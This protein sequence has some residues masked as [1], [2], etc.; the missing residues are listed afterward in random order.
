MARNGRLVYVFAAW[1]QMQDAQGSQRSATAGGREHNKSIF[2]KTEV[3]YKNNTKIQFF[4]HFL[5]TPDARVQVHF[6]TGKIRVLLGGFLLGTVKGARPGRERSRSTLPTT[7]IDVLRSTQSC[8]GLGCP[9]LEKKIYSS[10][11]NR[12]ACKKPGYWKK[13]ERSEMQCAVPRRAP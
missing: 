10:F 5:K 11:G 8:L 3:T 1:Y 7:P 12:K 2:K 9:I 13:R 6:K 4:L